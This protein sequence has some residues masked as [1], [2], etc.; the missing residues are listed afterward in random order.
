MQASHIKRIWIPVVR[1]HDW[2][3][4]QEIQLCF[5]REQWWRRSLP[6]VWG[7]RVSEVKFVVSVLWWKLWIFNACNI[8]FTSDLWVAV[9]NFGSPPRSFLGF[10]PA[11]TASQHLTAPARLSCRKLNSLQFS[12]ELQQTAKSVAADSQL[13]LQSVSAVDH[14]VVYPFSHGKG[15]VLCLPW[16]ICIKLP[17]SWPS[18]SNCQLSCDGQLSCN[19]QSAQLK[20]VSSVVD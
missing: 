11:Q 7:V 18:A 6:K 5:N 16:N 1:H 13:K 2:W 3:W 20:I 9:P 8:H 19:K 14:T 4:N 15:Q 10:I 17:V 12:A